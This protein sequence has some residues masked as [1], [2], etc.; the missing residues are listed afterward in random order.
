MN[1]ITFK[2]LVIT[3]MYSGNALI[4]EAEVR[5]SAIKAAIRFWWRAMQ[6]ASSGLELLDSETKIFGGTT[7]K[8]RRSKVQIF[9]KDTGVSQSDYHGEKFIKDKKSKG[10]GEPII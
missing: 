3:P 6:S 5:S 4:S 2:C 7:P 1:P 9:V 8:T 10:N